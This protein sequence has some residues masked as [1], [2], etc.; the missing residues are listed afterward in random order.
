VEVFFLDLPAIKIGH[1]KR[2][3]AE[4]RGGKGQGLPRIFAG[5]GLDSGDTLFAKLSRNYNSMAQNP[6]DPFPYSGILRAEGGFLLAL[7]I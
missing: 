1:P 6:I 5:V 4:R 3:S 2:L 7:N